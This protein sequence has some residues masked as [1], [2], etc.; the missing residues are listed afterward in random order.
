MEKMGFTKLLQGAGWRVRYCP[1]ALVVHD[2]GAS[3]DTDGFRRLVGASRWRYV[4][5]HWPIGRQIAFVPA[6]IFVML[7]RVGSPE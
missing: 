7:L 1:E 5:K 3:T 4:R 6:M 2:G